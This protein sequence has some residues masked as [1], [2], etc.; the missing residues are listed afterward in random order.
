ME[1]K[2]RKER[3]K[4]KREDGIRRGRKYERKLKDIYMK[5]ERKE[6]RNEN[7]KVRIFLNK[8]MQENAENEGRSDNSLKGFNTIFYEFNI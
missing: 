4:K 3:A 5:K 7:T 6:R 1:T 8:Y 2:R